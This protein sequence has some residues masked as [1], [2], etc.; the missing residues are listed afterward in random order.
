M[1]NW[2]R[3][4]PAGR[5]TDTGQQTRGGAAI[6]LFSIARKIDMRDTTCAI[7]DSTRDAGLYRRQS[8]RYLVSLR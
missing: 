5:K 8:L 1:R 6:A 7:L 2:R 3:L 4:A